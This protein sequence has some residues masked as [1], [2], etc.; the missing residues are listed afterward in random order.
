MRRIGELL[1]TLRL[2]F[3]P[4]ARRPVRYCRRHGYTHR[5]PLGSYACEL[6]Y[7]YRVQHPTAGIFGRYS[8]AFASTHGA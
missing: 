5:T 1:A 4:N 7:R 2:W 3:W 6:S 8:G